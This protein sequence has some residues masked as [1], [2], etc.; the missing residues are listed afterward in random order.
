MSVFVIM[1]GVLVALSILVVYSNM[2]ICFKTI[3][4]PLIIFGSIL[5]FLMLQEYLGKPIEIKE[6]S[7]EVI[8]YGQVLDK[9]NELIYMLLTEKGEQPPANYVTTEFKENLAKALGEGQAKS[10]GKPFLLKTEKK[11]EGG[12][13]GVP[14]EEGD[15]SKKSKKTSLSLKSL[16]FSV[17]KLPPTRMPEK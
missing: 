4:V 1:L 13:G 7:H 14:K 9:E 16:S 11:G 8:V 2:H 17:H 10:G 6:I 5:S 3:L 15:E 12:E